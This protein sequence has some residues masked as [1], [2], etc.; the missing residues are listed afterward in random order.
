MNYLYS[1]V[2]S[3][4]QIIKEVNVS[5]VGVIIREKSRQAG[6]QEGGKMPHIKNNRSLLNG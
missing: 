3:T 2:T 1:W 5:S 6:G 4:F